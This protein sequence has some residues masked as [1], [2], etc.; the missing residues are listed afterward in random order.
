[1]EDQRWQY[2]GLPA[3]T[4]FT[5]SRQARLLRL[6]GKPPVMAGIAMDSYGWLIS[7]KIHG[8]SMANP[9]EIYYHIHKYRM[10]LM[11]VPAILDILQN[12]P[13]RRVIV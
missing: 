3:A 2:I 8:K 10:I 1:M 13:H 6:V 12:P 4:D 7:W 9:Y 11:G 5:F